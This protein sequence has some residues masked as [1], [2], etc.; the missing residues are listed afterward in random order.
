MRY[1]RAPGHHHAQGHETCKTDSRG[2]IEYIS[3]VKSG[4][5]LHSRCQSANEREV[6]V[7]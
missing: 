6:V 4:A 3:S 5:M 1:S 7:R 2:A